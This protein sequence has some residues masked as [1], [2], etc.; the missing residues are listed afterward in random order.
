MRL[1]LSSTRLALISTTLC[2]ALA[3][4]YS[5]SCQ[6]DARK[7]F[8]SQREICAVFLLT[9]WLLTRYFCV[10]G[11]GKQVRKRLWRRLTAWVFRKGIGNG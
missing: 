1:W 5:A 11:T 2:R 6:R 7:R 4:A 3:G 9:E 8:A 10:D